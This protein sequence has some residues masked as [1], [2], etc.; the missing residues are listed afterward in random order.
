MT[1]HAKLTEEVKLA[2][3]SQ[4]HFKVINVRTTLKKKIRKHWT[5][6]GNITVLLSTAANNPLSLVFN[7][8]FL[9]LYI[10]KLLTYEQK[11]KPF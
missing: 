8:I 1:Y 11:P 6:F 3:H 4:S 5:T 10:L 7:S 2:V 9:K